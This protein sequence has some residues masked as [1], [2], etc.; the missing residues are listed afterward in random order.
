[1]SDAYASPSNVVSR[2]GAGVV[3]GLAGGL[4]LGAILQVMGE[5]TDF[6][7]LAGA[8]TYSVAWTVLLGICAVAGGLFGVLFGRF[9]SR[10][11]VSAIGV[12]LVYGGACGVL[13]AL[14]VLPLVVGDELLAFE[15][16]MPTLGAYVL[17]AVAT[18]V[19]YAV[20]GPRRRYWH[21]PR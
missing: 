1:M 13:L 21:Y 7:E 14:L 17:F 15:A 3:G 10:Q 12:G 20:A 11:I 5:V 16:N 8:R 19:V 4:L 9:I 18:G 2:A 6:A